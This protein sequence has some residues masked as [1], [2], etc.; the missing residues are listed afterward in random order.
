M[1]NRTV[2][3]RLWGSILNERY[4]RPPC[5]RFSMIPFPRRDSTRLIFASRG[6]EFSGQPKKERRKREIL[7]IRKILRKRRSK[8]SKSVSDRWYT[9]YSV[10]FISCIQ[11]KFMRPRYIIHVLVAVI[12]FCLNDIF[13]ADHL[14]PTRS[15]RRDSEHSFR[16]FR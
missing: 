16:G 4:S 10:Y 2:R 1:Y 3:Q 8:C 11:W 13:L 12:S 7:W 15:N 5:Q 9:V 14:T 6:E